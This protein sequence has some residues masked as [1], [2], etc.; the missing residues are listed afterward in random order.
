MLQGYCVLYI[1][2][3]IYRSVGFERNNKYAKTILRRQGKRSCVLCKFIT[4]EATVISS[5][6]IFECIS[7]GCM[8]V[9]YARSNRHEFICFSEYLLW[10]KAN[11]VS[12]LAVSLQRVQ[13]S[14][15]RLNICKPNKGRVA[16]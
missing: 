10:V 8:P 16:S 7:R 11:D 6:A 5:F 13:R 2:F 15:R 14:E 3:W 4:P 12:Y 9:C 1:L